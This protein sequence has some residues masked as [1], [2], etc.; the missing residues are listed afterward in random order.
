MRYDD[1]LYGLPA[2]IDTL[3]LYHN[4]T[5]TS[6]PPTTVEQL[7]EEARAGRGVAMSSTFRDLFWGLGAYGVNVYDPQ[8]GDFTF[9]PGGMVNWL[10]ILQQ[11]RDTPGVI[12]DPDRQALRQLFTDGKVT[13]YAG[14]VSGYPFLLENMG[15]DLSLTPLP[16][17][18][19]G[20]ASPF[21]TTNAFLLNSVSTAEQADLALAFARFATNAEQQAIL[22]RD[23][24]LVPANNLTRVS[25]GLYPV[26]AAFEAQARTAV[27]Y[28]NDP[29]IQQMFS[30]ASDTFSRVVEGLARPAEAVATLTGEIQHIPGQNLLD[31]SEDIC[32]NSGTLTVTSIDGERSQVIL[33]A[34]ADGFVDVCPNAVV[35]IR[36]LSPLELARSYD[37][38]EGQRWVGDVLYF[39]HGNLRTAVSAGLIADITQQVDQNIIQALRPTAVNA[40]RIDGRQY[41]IPIDVDVQALYYNRSLVRDAAGTLDDLRTQATAG[42]PVV[43]DGTFQRGYWGV[44]AFGGHLFDED[45]RFSLESDALIDWLNWLVMSRDDFG[46]RVDVDENL[47][48]SEFVDGKSAY[49]IGAAREVEELRQDIGIDNLDVT[50]FPEGPRGPGRP[51]VWTSGLAM[52]DGIPTERQDLALRF[53]EYAVSPNAQTKL[54]RDHALVPANAGVDTADRPLIN[55]FVTQAQDAEPLYDRAGQIVLQTLLENLFEQVLTGN[56]SPEQAVAD[57]YN[58]L[59]ELL[60]NTPNSCCPRLYSRQPMS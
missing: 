45:D 9:S 12:L 55:M 17:G 22:M 6:T 15:N 28:V 11:A 58:D 10:T 38:P 48:R 2:S 59:P 52:A 3:G 18:P 57:L 31:T 16:S 56:E 53:M 21:V 43:L 39:P 1:K 7:L 26:A 27:P 51:F 32:F 29:A 49:Y 35:Q 36:E 13:Y 47:Q 46:I 37:S 34:L 23:G 14:E 44:G 41:G 40:L 4:N 42:I 19:N 20:A 24:L 60:G 33:Q 5:Q 8:S 50:I 30:L 54:M 25:P